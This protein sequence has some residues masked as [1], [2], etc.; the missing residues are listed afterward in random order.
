M[1]RS[2]RLT[3]DRQSLDALAA[4][5]TIFSF[6]ATSDA[7]DRFTLTLRGRGLAR[8]G[9]SLADVAAREL[10]QIDVRL[11]YGYPASPP[12]IRWLT[13]IWH[14]NISFSGFVNLADL[15]LIWRPD[16]PLDAICERLWDVVRCQ[17]MNP[18]RIS[19]HAAKSWF[20]KECTLTLPLDPRPLVDRPAASGMNIV[21]YERRG[22]R[23]QL[24]GAAASGEVL[25]IDEN[26]P[27]PALP[28]RKPYIPVGQRRTADDVL[29][30]GPE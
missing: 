17:D 12:D 25:F 20:E 15:G 29:Y 24:A 13:P 7:A 19:N 5:S 2:D 26:T 27:T 1:S 9:A 3:A 10:H 21:R 30:I 23:R 28:E 16:L 11:P 22:Q 6:E 18:D 14:P 4:A 8:D